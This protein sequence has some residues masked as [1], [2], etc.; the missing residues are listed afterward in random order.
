[1][2][3]QGRVMNGVGNLVLEMEDLNESVISQTLFSV[4]DQENGYV[5]LFCQ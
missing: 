4:R 2:P 5:G 1:M 3:F